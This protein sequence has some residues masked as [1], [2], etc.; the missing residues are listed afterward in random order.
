VTRE[1]VACRWD[2]G[3]SPTPSTVVQIY[4]LGTELA[5]SPAARPPASS[6]H[7]PTYVVVR[8]DSARGYPLP[9][10]RIVSAECDS[11]E[12]ALR[13]ATERNREYGLES[14]Y[15]PPRHK[16]GEQEHSHER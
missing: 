15:L 6:R 8:Q 1:Y 7:E 16:V 5:A 3:E 11:Y 14:E 9:Y 10:G 12:H 13:E 2:A 4:R